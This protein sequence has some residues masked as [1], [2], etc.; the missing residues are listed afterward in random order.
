MTLASGACLCGDVQYE[1]SAD[2]MVQILCYCTDCQ[3]VSGAGGY[4]AYFVPLDC[5]KQT[6]AQL[7]TYSVTGN[8]GGTDSR[9]FCTTCGT[10]MWAELP[11]RNVASVNGLTLK[12]QTQVSPVGNHMISSKPNWCQINE[13]LPE[14]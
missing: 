8:S 9:R 5:L 3:T 2:P 11:E 7:T 14:I 13:A 10:R 12:G 4:A 1:I 6:A